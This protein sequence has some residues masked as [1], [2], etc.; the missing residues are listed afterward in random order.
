MSQSPPNLVR[1]F[2]VGSVA[3]LLATAALTAF[4][5]S[6]AAA[7]RAAQHR[8]AA[9]GPMA[10]LAAA[11]PRSV[12]SGVI[13]QAN[14]GQQAMNTAA[15]AI[16]GLFGVRLSTGAT[17]PAAMAV[18]FA[19]GTVLGG[20]YGALAEVWPTVTVG[21]G[22]AYGTAVWLGAVELACPALGL[23]APP[24]RN[25]PPMHAAGWSVHL[26]YGAVLEAGRRA[27]FAAACHRRGRC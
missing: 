6:T 7:A 14:A 17:M 8:A 16:A 10:G 15:D 3:G 21:R 1:G 26:V 13:R 2:A 23:M 4:Q 24:D 12:P 19:L 27:L 25:P 18:H 20:L 5:Q 9:R 11:D 22:T